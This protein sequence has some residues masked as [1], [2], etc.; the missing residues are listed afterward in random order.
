MSLL[1]FYKYI[2][3]KF[4]IKLVK[5]LAKS[6]AA[7]V[8]RGRGAEA[9]DRELGIITSQIRLYLSTSF[10]RAQSLCLINRLANL[11]DGAKAAAGQE[12]GG[13]EETR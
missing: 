4:S 12:V 11:G 2:L 13:G 5:V 10:V 1:S 9:S 3:C 8:T 6:K 7:A